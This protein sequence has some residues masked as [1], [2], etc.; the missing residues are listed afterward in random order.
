MLLYT[1]IY[2]T[3]S[4][5]TAVHLPKIYKKN[6]AHSKKTIRTITNSNYTAHTSPLFNSQKILPFKHLI[7]YTQ[8]LLV[9]SIYHKYSPPSPH[10]TW[11]TNSMRNDIRE[12]CNADDLYIP[13]ARTELNFALPKMWNKL[14]EQKF[15]PN[16]TTFKIA[17]KNHFRSLTNP[18]PS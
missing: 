14:S 16:P 9:H 5:S 12:L 8:S 13:F 3:D 6:G 15:T 17:I 2:C 7:T 11:R 1:H 10:N 4:R 18:P